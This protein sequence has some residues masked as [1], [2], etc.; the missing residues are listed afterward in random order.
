MEAAKDFAESI[1]LEYEKLTMVKIY[2][3]K[4]VYAVDMDERFEH[5]A[6][7]ID[8][9][10]DGCH[11]FVYSSRNGKEPVYFVSEELSNWRHEFYLELLKIARE[12]KGHN[13]FDE[14]WAF[15]EASCMSKETMVEAMTW[16]S[17][18]EYADIVSM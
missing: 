9:D 5:E 16:N 12:E 4:Y 1:E 10:G 11:T 3:G 15:E 8:A 6:V 7:A 13:G 18:K 2:D 14:R 17:P